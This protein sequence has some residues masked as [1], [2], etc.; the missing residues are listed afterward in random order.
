MGFL[1]RGCHMEQHAWSRGLLV[2][3]AV[4]PGLKSKCDASPMQVRKGRTRRKSP[5]TNMLRTLPAF[6]GVSGQLQ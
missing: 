5:F 2:M 4:F 6:L 1:S 3:R